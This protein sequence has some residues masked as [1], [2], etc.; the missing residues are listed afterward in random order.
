MLEGK[1]SFW[2]A[3]R[4]NFYLFYSWN[5]LYWLGLL[6]SVTQYLQSPQWWK[7]LF[8]PIFQWL[9]TNSL[10][11]PQS[12]QPGCRRVSLFSWQTLLPH[13][14]V[15]RQ[16]CTSQLGFPQPL[17]LSFFFFLWKSAFFLSASPLPFTS[18]SKWLWALLAAEANPPKPQDEC[19]L[20][21]LLW[22]VMGQFLF[23]AFITVAETWVLTKYPVA[24]PIP[25]SI[26]WLVLVNGQWQSG[27]S[28]S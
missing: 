1:A 21:P 23:P 3:L 16:M 4:E 12:A 24:S 5:S 22:N 18:R 9:Q 15:W 26:I 19:H 11:S 13:G 14:D 20:F 27:A 6:T 17:P 7:E 10:C 2:K 28:L 25:A 8:F